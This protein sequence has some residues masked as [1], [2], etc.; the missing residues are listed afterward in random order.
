MTREFEKKLIE[1]LKKVVAEIQDLK[2]SFVEASVIRAVG[3]LRRK[4]REEFEISG[5]KIIGKKLIVA[6]KMENE[7]YVE[8]SGRSECA[9]YDVIALVMIVSDS[10]YKWVI[11]ECDYYWDSNPEDELEEF[12]N[13]RYSFADLKNIP[14]DL[15][16]VF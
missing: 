9:K 13:S 10:S 11:E 16:V 1:E 15:T 7:R 4:E 14:N 2:E 5:D 12:V 8:Y 3:R 6:T